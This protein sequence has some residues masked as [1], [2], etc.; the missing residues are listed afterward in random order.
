MY[1]EL[2]GVA[3]G[4]TEF[5]AAERPRVSSEGGI[6]SLV[7]G[8]RSWSLDLAL[9]PGAKAEAIDGVHPQIRISGGHWRG[10]SFSFDLTITASDE[11]GEWRV[12]IQLP[13][14][15]P[16]TSQSLRLEAWLKGEAAILSVEP[17][18]FEFASL[19]TPKTT[20]AA[21]GGAL[22]ASITAE[23]RWIFTGEFSLSTPAL[24]FQRFEIGVS[25]DGD[26]GVEA[27]KTSGTAATP[28][29]ALKGGRH[30]TASGDP[31][32][33]ALLAKPNETWS[34][35]AYDDATLSTD[36]T[37]PLKVFVRNLYIADVERSLPAE[38]GVASAPPGESALPL[39]RVLARA[40]TL[41]QGATPAA[42][43]FRLLQGSFAEEP[44]GMNF[45]GH[46]AVLA[47]NKEFEI[48]FEGSPPVWSFDAKLHAIETTVKGADRARIAFP[49]PRDLKLYV[50]PVSAGPAVEYLDLS[51]GALKVQLAG[52]R[53]ELRRFRDLLNLEAEL[54][55]YGMAIDDKGRRLEP[56]K[57]WNGEPDVQV[58]FYFAA[59]HI[60]E[61]AFPRQLNGPTAPTGEIPFDAL[62]EGRPAQPSRLAFTIPAARAKDDWFDLDRLLDWS[63]LEQVAHF[64]A[65]HYVRDTEDHLR[66]D[67]GGSSPEKASRDQL[68]SAAQNWLKKPAGWGSPGRAN[69]P[70]AIEM[71]YRLWL[72]PSQ[73]A[74][75]KVSAA[76][77]P[78]QT[79]H[80]LW[81]ASLS[82]A[83]GADSVRAIWSRGL[84]PSFLD[85]APPNDDFDG[86]SWPR[87]DGE[88]RIP[89]PAKHRRE[90]VALTAGRLLPALK[91]LDKDGNNDP[92]GSVEALKGSYQAL[93]PDEGIYIPRPFRRAE[94]RLTTLGGTLLLDGEWSPPAPAPNPAD[95]HARNWSGLRVS[96]TS[97]EIYLGRTIEAEAEIKGYLFPLGHRAS[98]VT[99]HE[100]LFFKHPDSPE[101]V[102]YLIER[103]YIEVGDNEKVFPALGQPFAGRLLGDTR[104]ITLLGRQTPDLSD[105]EHPKLP[106]LEPASIDKPN[107]GKLALGGKLAFWPRLGA[108]RGTEHLFEFSI[109][110]APGAMRGPLM[111]LDNL[112]VHDPVAMRAVV[113][114]YLGAGAWKPN[115]AKL[116]PLRRA[117]FH[118][119]SL[120]YA[121]SE[122]GRG[123][124]GGASEGRTDLRTRSW[125]LG[126]TGRAGK[127]HDGIKVDGLA[128]IAPP[129]SPC[130]LL[131]MDGMMEG[132]DQPPFYPAIAA[133]EVTVQSIERIAG[134][135][136][137]PVLVA[138]NHRYALAGFDPAANP[139]ELFLDLLSADLDLS[140]AGAG[141]ASGGL[142]HTDM[143]VVHLSRRVGPV[144][145]SAIRRQ[146]PTAAPQAFL[147]EPTAAPAA[148]GSSPAE[149]GRLDPFDAL[150]NAKLLGI[151]PLKL[152]IRAAALGAAPKLVETV[153]SGAAQL[154]DAANQAVALARSMAK[155]VETALA[156]LEDQLKKAAAEM[157]AGADWRSVYPDLAK[158]LDEAR[159][160]LLKA[161]TISAAQIFEF[162]E[163]FQSTLKGLAE[164]LARVARDPVP[165]A[166]KA[167]IP[168][169]AAQ[170]KA[171]RG[172]GEAIP[173]GIRGQLDALSA[174]LEA[175]L[176]ALK[177]GEAA[178]I[179]LGLEV[180]G[181]LLFDPKKA[182]E[183][184][185]QLHQGL[186]HEVIGQPLADLVGTYQEAERRLGSVEKEGLDLLLSLMERTAAFAA[187]IGAMTEAAKLEATIQGQCKRIG[188]ALTALADGVAA[189]GAV[190][191]RHL[192]ALQAALAG[193]SGRIGPD[194]LNLSFVQSRDKTLQVVDALLAGLR[195]IETERSAL[196]KA[197]GDSCDIARLDG[198]AKLMRLRSEAVGRARD[199][200]LH[201]SG[202]IDLL[203][204]ASGA[205]ASDFEK[206][207]IGLGAVAGELSGLLK[208]LTSVGAVGQP[209]GQALVNHVNA[210][211]ASWQSAGLLTQAE[212]LRQAVNEINV[213]GQQ[214]A[215]ALDTALA[216]TRASIAKAERDPGQL[217]PVAGQFA[218]IA[219]QVDRRAAGL[220]AAGTRL[221]QD[222]I[223]ALENWS[224]GGLAE[225]AKIAAA[226]YA[227]GEQALKNVDTALQTPALKSS[228]EI[229]L[230]PE[231]L[232]ALAENR[233]QVI[234]EAAELR[235][236]AADADIPTKRPAARA[237]AEKVIQRWRGS[238]SGAAQPALAKAARDLAR[239]GETLVSGQIAQ[240]IDV[241]AIER[242]LRQ[243]LARLIPISSTVSYDW[244]TTLGPFPS[245]DNP[246]FQML[247]LKQADLDPEAASPYDLK[248]EAKI[249]VDLLGGGGRSV[250][251]R[252]TLK[253]FRVNLLGGFQLVSIDFSE[254][255][256]SLDGGARFDV[257]VTG[258][259]IKDSL[260]FIQALQSFMSGGGATGPYWSIRPPL[261]EVGYRFACDQIVLGALMFLNVALEA[262][263]E[264]ALDGR[265]ARFRFRL[266]SPERP[267]LVSS[268]PYG[269]GGYAL[270]VANARGIVAF[271]A[272]F[273]FGA[274]TQ[275]KFGPLNAHGR[276]TAGI[277][278]SQSVEQGAVIAGFVNA[279][280]EGRIACFGVSVN[281]QVRLEHKSSDSSMIGT[282]TYK[283]S[284]RV[285]FAK[286]SYKFTARYTFSGGKRRQALALTAPS[287]LVPVFT[288]RPRQTELWS[289][290]AAQF[291]LGLLDT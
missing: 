283:V 174:R 55:N 51:R 66:R 141:G 278:I 137:K 220:V 151:V 211:A 179:L 99:R 48:T 104:R 131:T 231:V 148:V 267:L 256:F 50:T 24:K 136:P 161:P 87:D 124:D 205:P 109:D 239:L 243:E 16:N 79:V 155:Q 27:S 181:D 196:A 214:A 2:G 91:R 67:L 85:T 286:I 97:H 143:K 39:G 198:V 17:K 157:L 245:G 291:D 149:S 142:A 185:A 40:Q 190:L 121:P 186:L 200:A 68:L 180:P 111:F 249:K 78:K 89:F 289:A 236:I 165:A 63:G 156:G 44:S 116:E 261:I 75:W 113:E 197:L 246:I 25:D 145:G 171:L 169:I 15:A 100:R 284:F 250:Q 107:R 60:A 193:M 38:S 112:V 35:V 133:A 215:K 4:D 201:L 195:A 41:S 71:P 76:P 12:K 64:T 217:L 96:R 207:K 58:N 248:L 235:Q 206:N 130:E 164:E 279:V 178:K 225:A 282:S 264:L 144:G 140:F 101:P 37:T 43:R 251:G 118:G 152:V 8:D 84:H 187:A 154:E 92:S 285:G 255:H 158:R 253:P 34:L 119:D 263:A 247:P 183:L 22:T 254:A 202:L 194:G 126:V 94:M 252:G 129:D 30:L 244:T 160:A 218:E 49:E 150:P 1:D 52:S 61:R 272:S 59:Q 238:G 69:L 167:I 122:D 188:D 173:G 3:V 135:A 88:F 72:S 223:A 62:V 105:P 271:E 210:L 86:S 80:R 229:L 241:R 163:R 275:L 31:E 269:G 212:Q 57:D 123:D 184:V 203:A 242:A 32:G 5:D 120:R 265:D 11:S 14:L 81:S 9:V 170:W 176:G 134:G 287:T 166:I 47:G 230:R 77:D 273:E 73:K 159:D 260:K 153:Q 288:N 204:E 270:I 95:P 199:V 146:R 53:M 128:G 147:E 18:R 10:T 274:V 98:Y 216:A 259:Q 138:P 226:L 21:S 23:N 54:D 182:D 234:A 281:I 46:I 127:P 19:A 162:V 172:I 36:G 93:R 45:A 268:P 224:Y 26:V 175:D 227:I 280:G 213:R 168:E 191:E 125:S 7:F 117:E 106:D 228:L 266:S 221:A 108:R 83:D 29:G 114:H 189:K 110:D 257:A 258:V 102:S 28:I 56:G 33:W 90:L 115:A 222:Q 20:I 219:T 6:A 103:K 42:Q 132:A 232:A 208:G 82:I 65:R 13:R 74:R 277:Y 233:K 290:Y 192:L 177:A 209:A 240:L 276:V 237:T 70:T 139:G 262:S